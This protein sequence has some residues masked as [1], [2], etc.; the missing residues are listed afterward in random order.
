MSI[1]DGTL[2]IDCYRFNF[3][4]KSPR[5]QWKCDYHAGKIFSLE[6]I[7][8]HSVL[9]DSGYFKTNLLLCGCQ[10]YFD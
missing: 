8:N 1:A 4:I 9:S 3:S 6:K 10:T 7:C 5:R 2:D